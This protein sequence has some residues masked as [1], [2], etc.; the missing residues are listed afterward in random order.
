MSKIL[1]YIV[2]FCIFHLVLVLWTVKSEKGIIWWLILRLRFNFLVG[3]AVISFSNT[4]NK[5]KFGVSVSAFRLESSKNVS[6]FR[7][8]NC[9][10]NP[11][12]NFRYY[13]GKLSIHLFKNVK[14]IYNYCICLAM[15]GN[16]LIFMNDFLSIFI[17]FLKF[18]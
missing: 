13:Q 8:N 2:Y 10:N 1:P 15:K 12:W 9:D 17:L 18:T 7:D 16:P 11:L 3:G 5:G 4:P 14:N 6:L